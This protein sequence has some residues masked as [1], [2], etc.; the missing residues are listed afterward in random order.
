MHEDCLVDLELSI[1]CG[2]NPPDMQVLDGDWADG[3]ED[4]DGYSC[5]FIDGNG[6]G[7][8]ATWIGGG[9]GSGD[10]WGD[11]YGSGPGD[12]GSGGPTS[13]GGMVEGHQP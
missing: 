6:H 12:G 8:G 10:G 4:G 11:G 9:S 13:G 7:C 5:G 2:P 3:D 1:A